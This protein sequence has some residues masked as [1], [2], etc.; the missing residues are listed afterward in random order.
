MEA[1]LFASGEMVPW[2]VWQK[3][4]DWDR[5][6]ARA[7]A[8]ALRARL[9]RE[10]SALDIVVAEDGIA[11][12]TR[13]EYGELLDTF[14]GKDAE[15]PLSRPALETLALLAYRGPLTRPELDRVRGVHCGM[16]LRHLAMRG[17]VEEQEASAVVGEPRWAITNACLQ[18]L[19]VSQVEALP[20][21]QAWHENVVIQSVLK[22]P[23]S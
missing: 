6:Q 20:D 2:R 11:L 5:E 10:E 21:F 18:V 12:V 9:T 13:A 19:G 8:E 17:L 1:L 23:T 7:H 22:P 15:E 3:H 4:C 14:L 16:I